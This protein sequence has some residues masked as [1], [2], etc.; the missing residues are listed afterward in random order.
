[1]ADTSVLYSSLQLNAMIVR[2]TDTLHLIFETGS[3]SAIY[4]PNS[5][6]ELLVQYR[7][8]RTIFFLL[9]SDIV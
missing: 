4:L 8:P 9:I 5:F 3:A 2:T 6:S 1:M 7:N